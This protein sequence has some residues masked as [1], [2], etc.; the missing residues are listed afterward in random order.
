MLKTGR[1]GRVKNLPGYRLTLR[2]TERCIRELR[3]IA[4]S[5]VQRQCSHLGPGH[6]R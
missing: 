5:E 1:P 3:I 2:Y 4:A 6:V